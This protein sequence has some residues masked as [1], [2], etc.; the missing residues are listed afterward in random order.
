MSSESNVTDRSTSV[1]VEVIP[2]AELPESRNEI[3]SETEAL[4]DAIRKRAQSEVQ[5]ASD[6]TREAYL[7]AVRQAREAIEQNQLIDP[8]RIEESIE[9]LQ[10]DTEKNWQG[11]VDEIS[12]F[13]DRLSE[14]V[15]AAWEKL[16]DSDS[17][18]DK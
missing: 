6:F 17:N 11:L 15:K 13:G 4:I 8:Q 18:S 7:K 5:S 3:R 2:A 16:A 1:A 14:A 9:Q 10:K 12:G